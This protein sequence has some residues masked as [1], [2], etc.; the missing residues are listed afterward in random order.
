M[1]VTAENPE[2]ASE[3]ANLCATELIE[4]ANILHSTQGSESLT[5]YES[6]LATSKI[7]LQ[8]A[9]SDLIEFQALNRTAVISKTLEAHFET[10]S[11]H[12]FQLA[13]MHLLTED[14]AGMQQ[15][16]N[17]G[18]DDAPI[19]LSTELTLISLQS[20]VFDTT[21]NPLI[22]QLTLGER[23]SEISR[24]DQLILLNQLEE[25]LTTQIN[26]LEHNLAE[27]E[28]EILA[29]QQEMQEAIV[30]YEQLSS[31]I[32]IAK[33]NYISLARKVSE[34]RI[35]V[36][37]IAPPLTLVSEATPPDEPVTQ[38][39]LMITFVA[40]LLGFSMV[41]AYL[42]LRQWWQSTPSTA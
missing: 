2:A 7:E 39:T 36:Q 8:E 28:P 13:D 22:L 32:L 23:Q 31:N 19:P 29:L 4:L 16:L 15:L 25:I 41:A 17:N 42:V 27:L 14:I 21:Q 10:Q 40:A 12:L 11:Q 34:E 37:D 24:S 18:P 6:E 30:E 20:K 33:E 9:E 3:I 5:F 26:T 35:A 1:T 38:N